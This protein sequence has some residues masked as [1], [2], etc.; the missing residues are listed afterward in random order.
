M[1]QLT[2]QAT[3]TNYYKENSYHSQTH[4]IDSLQAMHF[5]MAVG[6]LHT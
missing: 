1:C 2:L 5:F 6:G 3:S 4:I